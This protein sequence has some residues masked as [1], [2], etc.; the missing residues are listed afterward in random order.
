MSRYSKDLLM[1]PKIHIVLE[2][3]DA[4][5]WWSLSWSSTT[6]PRSF[7][8]D[9]ASSC[10]LPSIYK[11]KEI[12]QMLQFSCPCIYCYLYSLTSKANSTC[13]FKHNLSHAVFSRV[14]AWYEYADKL[15]QNRSLG[16]IKVV[17]FK[18]GS[19]SGHKFFTYNATTRNTNVISTHGRKEKLP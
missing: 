16:R 6:T 2:A 3:T 19:R 18:T 1:I 11:S 5:C 12:Y 10:S 15:I 4:V 13:I 14:T 7:S 17:K 8:E 9:T